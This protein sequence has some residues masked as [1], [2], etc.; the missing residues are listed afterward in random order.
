MLHLENGNG[1][2]LKIDLSYLNEIV[3]RSGFPTGIEEEGRVRWNL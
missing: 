2:T 3:E 1:G